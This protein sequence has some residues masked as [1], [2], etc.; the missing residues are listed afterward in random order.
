MSVALLKEMFERMVV[1]KDATL[2]ATY[3]HHEFRMTSNGLEQGYDAFTAGHERIYRTP[4]SY[5]FR[6][7]EQAWVESADRVAGRMWV[8][9]ER[10][11]TNATEIEIVLI[12][13]FK[14]GRI[15]RVWELTWPD[16]SRMKE[17]DDYA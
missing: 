1:A 16:W 3:Y 6:Y 13:T 4:I 12:A 17:F 15:H 8:T 2:L 9:T 10:P 7:D 11:D 14:D 5:A